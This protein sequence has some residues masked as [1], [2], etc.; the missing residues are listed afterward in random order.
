MDDA[1]QWARKSTKQA[2]QQIGKVSVRLVRVQVSQ[3]Q[4]RPERRFV[5]PEGRDLVFTFVWQPI[6]ITVQLEAAFTCE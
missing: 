1:L 4:T 6:R 3:V 5:T 2:V